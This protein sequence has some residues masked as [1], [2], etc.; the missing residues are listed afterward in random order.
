MCCS[1]A[2][3]EKLRA[4]EAAR[5]AAVNDRLKASRLLDQSE[6]DKTGLDVRV[7]ELQKA[8]SAETGSNAKRIADLETANAIAKARCDELEATNAK[9]RRD[10]TKLGGDFQRV[11]NDFHHEKG[12]R[13]A[14]EKEKIQV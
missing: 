5:S 7:L 3:E 9:L 1:S 2:L 10:Y 4:C 11:T 6:Q 13:L 8:M 12:A 14:L